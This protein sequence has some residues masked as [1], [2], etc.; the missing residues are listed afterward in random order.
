VS[1][2]DDALL[3]VFI[4]RAGTVVTKRELW[5]ALWGFVPQTD[6]GR[7]TSR[8]LDQAVSRLRRKGVPLVNVW[9]VGWL[10]PEDAL[11]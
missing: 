5:L 2:T 10:L 7:L 8:A 9:G 4:E 3:A 6:Y 1:R 11:R